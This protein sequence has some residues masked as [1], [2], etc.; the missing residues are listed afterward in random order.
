[1]R[2]S[3]ATILAILVGLALLT[4]WAFQVMIGRR[5]AGGEVYAPGSSLRTDP[6]GTRAL[7]DALNRLPSV[8]ASRNFRNL[9]K[10]EG[11]PGS[12][13]VVAMVGADL[14][15]EGSKLNGDALMQFAR[16]GGR[17][18]ITLKG[19]NTDFERLMESAE[20]RREENRK[21]REEERS[22]WREKKPESDAE[23]SPTS[24]P[25]DK[26]E[27][28]RSA[29][30]QER[31]KG[32]RGTRAAFASPSS[33]QEVLGVEV[34]Q[35]D[36]VL[37]VKGALRLEPV[38]PLPLDPGFLPGWYTRTSVTFPG[39]SKARWKPLATAG[40]KVML[41]LREEGAG[42]IILATDSYFL[43]NEALFREPASR[44]I[45][46]WVGGASQ[47]I[48]EET[49]LGTREDP[50]IM[51]LARRHRLHGLFLG[52]LLLFAL[53]VWRSSMSLVPSRGDDAPS[54]TVAG[55]GATAGLVSMLRR[56]IPLPQVLRK[57]LEAW[58]QGTPRLTPVQQ[59]RLD[60]ARGHL[61]PDTARQARPGALAG[62]Y[63]AIS[64]SLHARPT[65]PAPVPPSSSHD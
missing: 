60:Q 28:K 54:R 51:T 36:F 58:E 37:T 34:E 1:M 61:P 3:P 65:L 52:G 63:R 59:T 6:L 23:P 27:P 26:L 20:E 13:L 2:R 33:L 22:R 25:E 18:L 62:L 42:S 55:R 30:P 7:H 46:W 8:R 12:T 29:D 32:E 45:S 40:D 39:S 16:A 11:A 38:A 31:K 5:F 24:P 10:L 17:V 50:G 53:F 44:F 57:G 14:F 4:A 19:Q 35:Q 21:K 41:A 56:G 49:H 48:F 43:T 15:T 64:S 47:V 9:D